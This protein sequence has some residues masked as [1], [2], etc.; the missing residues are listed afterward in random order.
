VTTVQATLSTDVSTILA[1]PL[2][3]AQTAI[4]GMAKLDAARLLAE[5]SKLPRV[6]VQGDDEAGIA[7]VLSRAQRAV[8]R[9]LLLD[10]DITVWTLDDFARAAGLQPTAPTK[11]RNIYLTTGV[12]SENGL[13][14][15]D[16]P[17]ERP[18]RRPGDPKVA[19]AG[20]PGYAPPMTYAGTGRLWLAQTER[21]DEDLYPRSDGKGR[22]PPG[23][24]PGR[25]HDELVNA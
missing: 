3:V 12:V 22:K 6:M 7:P 20:H 8:R 2:N 10:D 24:T 19:P 1:M 18:Y 16:V 13:I 23:R 4:R 15:P 9:Q 11:W 5:L 17:T 14:A 25:R 21:V